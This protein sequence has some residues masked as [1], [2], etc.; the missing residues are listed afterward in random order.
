MSNHSTDDLRPSVETTLYLYGKA[1]PRFRVAGPDHVTVEV[2]R[3]RIA[4]WNP[5]V[6]RD[7]A[8]KCREAADELETARASEQVPA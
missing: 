2:D 7:F 1:A 3:L 8:A 5:D 6:L 4:A